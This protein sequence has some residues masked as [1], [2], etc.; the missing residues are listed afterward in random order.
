M[1]ATT[2]RPE[3]M[4]SIHETD[5]V[6]EVIKGAGRVGGCIHHILTDV[7]YYAGKTVAHVRSVFSGYNSTLYDR[8][9]EEGKITIVNLVR[10]GSVIDEADKREFY[11]NI[12]KDMVDVTKSGM[13]SENLTII[14]LSK[15][16]I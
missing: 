12:G 4:S 13:E 11:M 15:Y 10:S 5:F 2:A 9:S 7:M 14:D 8:K 6:Y 1:E 16:G 3:E